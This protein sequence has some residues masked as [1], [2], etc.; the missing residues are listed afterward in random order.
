MNSI[1]PSQD[2]AP[3]W[4][5]VMRLQKHEETKVKKVFMISLYDMKPEKQL[6]REH[7]DYAHMLQL[8]GTVQ[9][10]SP[11]QN[12]TASILLLYYPSQGLNL[13]LIV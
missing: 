9:L 2:T 3:D 8:Q 7:K 6:I 5:Q 13:C 12:K 4:T 11:L 10:F 1:F